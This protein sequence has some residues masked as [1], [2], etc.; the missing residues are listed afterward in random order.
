[1]PILKVQ[2]I[3]FKYMIMIKK[4]IVS[5]VVQFIV[6]TL[7]AQCDPSRIIDG[8]SSLNGS[9]SVTDKIILQNSV[10]QTGN[11]LQLQAGNKIQI[12]PGNGQV[13]IKPKNN[14]AGESSFYAG[15]NSQ[16]SYNIGAWYLNMYYHDAATAPGHGGLTY[17]NNT[18]PS[19][20][21][22]PL[23]SLATYAFK[24]NIFDHWFRVRD[25]ST[26]DP[27]AFYNQPDFF[28]STNF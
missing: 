7:Y 18:C 17:G 16:C 27:A 15:I 2:I 19:Q 14:I 13:L 8:A 11:A 28:K 23:C 24:Q 26:N 25:V 20:Y 10:N 21:S 4:I 12:L 9:F 6:L 22:G 1:M 3:Y 5:V